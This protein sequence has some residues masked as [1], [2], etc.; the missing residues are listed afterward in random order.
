MQ[1]RICQREQ[2]VHRCR[3]ELRT[4]RIQPKRSMKNQPTEKTMIKIDKMLKRNY[5]YPN[6]CRIRFV[7]NKVHFEKNKLRKTVAN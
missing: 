6:S 1:L 3:A 4:T 5:R 7:L 2:L